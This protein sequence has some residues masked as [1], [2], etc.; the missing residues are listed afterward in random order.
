M[1]RLLGCPG[2]RAL[3]RMLLPQG[4]AKGAGGS[5]RLSSQGPGAAVAVD[6]A[7]PAPVKSGG[8]DDSGVAGAVAKSSGK[9][10]PGAKYDYKLHVD[11]IHPASWGHLGRVRQGGALQ[12]SIY[13]DKALKIPFDGNYRVILTPN[14]G[15]PPGEGVDFR[16]EEGRPTWIANH[17]LRI[18]DVLP[19][20]SYRL[21]VRVK[22]VEPGMPLAWS[23]D[24]DV[25]G[26]ALYPPFSV[27]RIDLRVESPAAGEVVRP[28]EETVFLLWHSNY[29]REPG[30][31]TPELAFRFTFLKGE[32][33]LH[34]QEINYFGRSGFGYTPFSTTECETGSDY[35]IQVA[36]FNPG[37][38]EIY[39]TASTGLF[40]IQ[41]S[42]GR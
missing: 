27:A 34:R 1:G 8:S 13:V 10:A 12:L 14:P 23:R 28:I 15:T 5:T 33:M 36:L 18:P 38:G 41:Q 19:S 35:E 20:G 24:I 21:E 7:P 30:P 40:T 6:A 4:D 17:L 22:T 26:S 42:P 3:T 2:G 11:C 31:E 32:R 39:K 9:A 25:G 37:T 29:G 16:P